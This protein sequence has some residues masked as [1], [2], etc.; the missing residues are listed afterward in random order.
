MSVLVKNFSFEI[1]QHSPV[2]GDVSR[3]IQYD[4]EGNEI[5][6]YL[7]VDYPAI[8]ASLGSVRD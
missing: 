6:S 2:L 8:Q 7:P 3:S 4:G 1:D 5:I